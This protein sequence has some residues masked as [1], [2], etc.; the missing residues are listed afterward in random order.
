M[1]I[2]LTRLS[3]AELL[4]LNHRIVERLRTIRLARCRS[5]MMEFAVG[6]HVS[7]HPD[8]GHEVTGTVVRL[9]LKSVTVISADGHRW[10]VGPAL[11]TKLDDEARSD[12]L[13]AHVQGTLID[14]ATHQRR[15]RGKA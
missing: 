11:L 15:D 2:D 9:N 13:L 1:D 3:E 10:R 12:D 8:C 4:D 14:L 7:F 6:D 5:T